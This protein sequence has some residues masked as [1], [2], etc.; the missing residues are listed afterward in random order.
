MNH[1]FKRWFWSTNHKD[2]GTLYLLFGA[3]SGII[4]T[5]LSVLIRWELAEPGNQ[6]LL[7]N[8]Q[9]YNVVVTAHGLIMIFFMVMPI[10]IGGWGNWFIPLMLGSPDMAF[11]RLNNIS[12]WCASLWILIGYANLYCCPVMY[13]TMGIIH[14]LSGVVDIS[15]DSLS[16]YRKS[17][18]LPKGEI[19]EGQEHATNATT[20]QLVYN[21]SLDKF[22][23]VNN[24]VG[25]LQLNP[26]EHNCV[27]VSV[28]TNSDQRFANG[29]TDKH[30]QQDENSTPNKNINYQ[31]STT[32]LLKWSNPYGDGGLILGHS[33]RM[34]A[35]S[36]VTQ[37]SRSFITVAGNGAANEMKLVQT[38]K[39]FINLFELICTEEL[40]TQVYKKIR[41]NSGGMTPGVDIKRRNSKEAKIVQRIVKGKLV[42]SRINNTR[43]NFYM[44][45][46][47]IMKKLNEA[48][49]TKTYTA[50]SGE[51]KIVPN[52]IIKWIFLDHRSI[53]VR[54]NAV[55]RGL[56]NYYGFVDNNYSFHSIVNYI[57]HHSCAKTIARKLN[58]P[59]R[60]Q[61]F[62][63]YG[64]YLETQKEDKTKSV[65][66]FTLGS[67]KKNTK[68]LA[69]S[70]TKNVDP[71]EVT[72]WSLRS[73]INPFDLCWVCGETESVEI[74]HIRKGRVKSTGFTKLMS[75][76]N[77]KQIP[78]CKPCHLKIH[79]GLYN[80]ISLKNL[81][82]KNKK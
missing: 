45:V 21:E 17:C 1:W 49:Y 27:H 18:S 44:P 28:L 70:A 22:F 61:A 79:N 32:R 55:I 23:M 80:D 66:L 69:K 72:N 78:V 6:I 16:M 51:S 39:K 20:G 43:L 59:N 82:I 63:K 35:M 29:S 34:Q 67:F 74:K 10:M 41:S 57:L 75:N 50:Q 62:A 7:G 58:L 38:D 53:V 2:I 8:H 30:I 19:P 71:F 64:R 60:A 36:K 31:E 52:A 9:L 77:R 14:P 76:L 40:L 26:V 47:H 73:Q 37:L 25:W 24:T 5:G 56:I 65:K 68:L 15:V 12:F 3:F 33:S 48:G 42:K 11:P 13:M 81:Y 46:L 54:Y 4:G